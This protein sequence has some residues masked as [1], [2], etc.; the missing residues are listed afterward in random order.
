[1]EVPEA[2]TADDV[3]AQAPGPGSADRDRDGVELGELPVTD[4][5]DPKPAPRFEG[6]VLHRAERTGGRPL[7]WAVWAL[8]AVA[9]IVLVALLLTGVIGTGTDGAAAALD[10]AAR[11]LS[12]TIDRTAVEVPAA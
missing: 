7:L 2:D 11:T 6:T 5:P 1:A 4:A 8:I 10:D 12:P 3:T 9:L